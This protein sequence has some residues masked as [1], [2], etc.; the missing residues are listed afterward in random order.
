MAPL[1]MKTAV[2]AAALGLHAS[3]YSEAVKFQKSGT[4]NFQISEA[5]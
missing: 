4:L 1:A 5:I 3:D 2:V